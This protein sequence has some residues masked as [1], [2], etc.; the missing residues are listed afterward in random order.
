MTIFEL[1]ITVIDPE[2]GKTIKV[3]AL[4]N[5]VTRETTHLMSHQ[6]ADTVLLEEEPDG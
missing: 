4:I 3:T 5:N 6:S 1:P 2:S